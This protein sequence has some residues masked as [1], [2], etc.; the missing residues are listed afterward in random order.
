MTTIATDGK[1]MAGDGR[2]TVENLIYHDE[3]QK[4]FRLNDGR[5]V[6]V[7]GLA[8]TTIQFVEWLNDPNEPNKYPT[9]D[10]EAMVIDGSGKID[11]Y[12]NDEKNH[13]P[14]TFPCGPAAIGSGGEYALVAMDAGL[15]PKEAVKAAAKRDTGTGGKI[16]TMTVKP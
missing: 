10:F 3:F 2:V 8:R 15:S 7:S 1:T 12:G 5:I 16:R 14:L 11:I 6:G 13:K 9:N 4:I